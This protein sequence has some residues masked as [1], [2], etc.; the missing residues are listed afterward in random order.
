MY[1]QNLHT[2]TSF[3]DGAHS[4]EELV[5][6][7]LDKGFSSIGFSDHSYTYYSHRYA[8][9]GDK[10]EEYKKE[11]LRLKEKYKDQIKIYLGLEFDIYSGLDTSGYDYSI[12]SVHY[13]KRGDGYI[14]FDR[15]ALL[16]DDVIKMYFCGFGMELVKAYYHTLATL[17]DYGKFDIIG[18]FDVITKHLETHNFFDVT[19]KK[20][21]NYA[22]EAAE[23]LKGKIP[24][25]EVN[26]GAI[27]K[28]Y[29]T[30][31][32][33]SIPILKELNRLGFGAVITS[34]CHDK[35]M[36][37]CH[38]NEAAELLKVCG[39]KEKYIL[40]DNGFIPVSL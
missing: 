39:F 30:T 5:L 35:E 11:I 13:I 28:G 37:D 20:Y 33:P 3:C 9:L 19:S 29:R 31:P 17:P 7:A 15:N 14:D 18:H 10:T 36:L 4:P 23:A 22:F 40:T 38:F 32:Y 21:L 26:T 12:G 6:T 16:F 2:H 1:L 8:I 25:F 27:A 34:D 24:F